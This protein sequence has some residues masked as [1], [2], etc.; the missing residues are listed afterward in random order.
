P[1]I[2][3]KAPAKP[4]PKTWENMNPVEKAR[5]LDY[6]IAPTDAPLK[7]GQAG[8]MK[9]SV[10]GLASS[11]KLKTDLSVFN[12]SIT[13]SLSAQEIGL[14]KD[15]PL[16]PENINEA[17][18][19]HYKAY[20]KMKSLGE[21]PIDNQFKEAV[22]NIGNESSDA[23]PLDTSP[24][25][26]KLKQAYLEPD[27]FGANGAVL[28]IRQLR[29]DGN[30]N[31]SS[32]D[33]EKMQ[34]GYAQREIANQIENQIDRYASSRPE[35]FDKPN[36][37]P[38][39]RKARQEIAKI[40]TV[41]DSILPGTTDVSARVL[42][43]KL[44]RGQPLSGNLMKIAEMYNNFKPAMQDAGPLRNKT[45]INAMEGLVGGGLGTAALMS[46]NPALWKEMLFTLGARP[47]TRK[48]LLSG[49]SQNALIRTPPNPMI[50]YL[51]PNAAMGTALGPQAN[52]NLLANALLQNR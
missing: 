41:R 23:F 49:P 45:P 25:L 19:P 28:K 34:L 36:A 24:A 10:E 38:A 32:R 27:S 14:P 52:Q 22:S 26:N 11:P 8:L 18:L 47:L 7:G 40:E 13:N 4:V 29:K 2:G 39:F 3:R 30:L 12:Q 35:G 37:V 17:L 48:A 21:I 44:N 15:A 46:H 31:I 42:A 43:K 6:K 5:S 33:P 9:R 51:A 20:S 1:S 16:T 50:N